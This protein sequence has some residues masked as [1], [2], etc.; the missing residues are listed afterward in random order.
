MLDTQHHRLKIAFSNIE[1]IYNLLRSRSSAPMA[2]NGVF[3]TRLALG[4]LLFW[5]RKGS[6]QVLL[7]KRACNDFRLTH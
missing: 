4:L 7:S 3:V 2:D 1:R 6:L 5:L